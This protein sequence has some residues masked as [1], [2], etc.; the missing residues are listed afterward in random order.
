MGERNYL[1]L[2]HRGRRKKGVV[3]TSNQFSKDKY[4]SSASKDSVADLKTS[5]SVGRHY[6]TTLTSGLYDK[7]YDVDFTPSY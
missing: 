3:W 7:I 1:Q 5:A 6:D 2:A 4:K